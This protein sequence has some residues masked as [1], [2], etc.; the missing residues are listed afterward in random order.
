MRTTSPLQP[1]MD[2]VMTARER[3]RGIAIRTPLL[4]LHGSDS[5]WI[6]P[7]CLQPVGSFKMRGIYNA[8]AALPE[9][10]R[11]LG[12]ST[13]SSGNT[14]QALA[15]SA[16]RF[17]V[18]ARA[19]MPLTTA[20]NKVAATEAYGG[21]PDLMPGGQAFGYLREGG[22]QDF[23]DT[24]IHPVANRDVLAGHGTIGLEIDEDMPDVDEVYVPI[25]GGGLVSGISNVL[26]TLHSSVRIIGVQPS[27]CTPVI[28]GLA[29][30]EPV[31]VPVDTICDGVAVS[32]M[33]PEMYPLL[34]DLVDDIVTVSDDDVRHAI[35][36][37][38]LKNKIVAEG[39]GALAVAAAMKCD[40]STR[41][42][43]IISGGSI[44]AN[45][46]AAILDAD[47]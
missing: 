27:G 28:A 9:D 19:V 22:Y 36:Q 4:Q 10:Q 5:V 40:E 20:A 41:K 30:G 21:S 17:G 42:I 13:V 3:L 2:E 38:A 24:F 29:A 26:K 35:R 11:A 15:W 12:V 14:A 16:R 7:E 6:K 34:R 25:G 32:F 33:F 1:T 45:K 8:V 18:P 47:D 46:L 39:A 23:P 37:L 43:A 31:D 44:D